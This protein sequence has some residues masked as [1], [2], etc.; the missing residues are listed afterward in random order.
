MKCFIPCFGKSNNPAISSGLGAN[1]DG[2]EPN[3][4]NSLPT[5]SV[6][7]LPRAGSRAPVRSIGRA[8]NT[9]SEAKK[10]DWLMKASPEIG[11]HACPLS[12]KIKA[13]K[14]QLNDR[15]AL[16]YALEMA[17][18]S[19]REKVPHICRRLLAAYPAVETRFTV[20]GIDF[21]RVRLMEWT[22]PDRLPDFSSLATSDV[23][24]EIK[25]LAKVLKNSNS[26][27]VHTP[28]V[29]VAFADQL[30]TIRARVTA[31]NSLSQPAAEREIAEYLRTVPGSASALSGFN[32]AIGYRDQMANFGESVSSSIVTVWNYIRSVPDKTLQAQLKVSLASK[33]REI[34]IETPCATGMI[35]RII[36]TPTAI[37]FSITQHICMDEI[38]TELQ[39]LAASVNEAMEAEHGDYMAAL[40]SEAGESHIDGDPDEHFAAL[41]RDAFIQAAEVEFCKLR[42]LTKSLLIIEANRIFPAGTVI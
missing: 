2:F 20:F 34:G 3:G 4:S 42:G 35:E 37:D 5:K 36:D 32:R 39:T 13:G 16:C 8:F 11:D 1:H 24:T 17:I 14:R 7:I 31:A 15:E 22:Q 33:L 6:G 27:N 10:I 30:I 40:R 29:A 21:D 9:K 18:E 26:Q 28:A 38:R 12:G 25:Q 19:K 23:K 41:K